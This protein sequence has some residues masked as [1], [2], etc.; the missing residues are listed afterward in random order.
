MKCE[1]AGSRLTA[2]SQWATRCRGVISRKS[3]K[4]PQTDSQ[5]HPGYCFHSARWSFKHAN[6]GTSEEN[7]KRQC[8]HAACWGMNTQTW[9]AGLRCGSYGG[10]FKELTQTHQLTIIIKLFSNKPVALQTA[11][12]RLFM[13]SIPCI[14]NDINVN[15]T[16]ENAL[17]LKKKSESQGLCWNQYWT[18]SK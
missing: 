4:S 12:S 16:P 6:P 5:V 2:P 11:F 15:N 1:A 3:P 8:C 7:K 14:C 10:W 13:G 17:F 9:K 18:V